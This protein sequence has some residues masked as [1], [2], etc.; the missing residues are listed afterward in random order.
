MWLYGC[1]IEEGS[2]CYWMHL[3][4]KY[5]HCEFHWSQWFSA[6]CIDSVTSRFG[7]PST[8]PNC[9]CPPACYQEVFGIEATRT[10]LPYKVRAV[11]EEVVS[12]SSSPRAQTTLVV[13]RSMSELLVSLSSWRLSR[14][15]CTMNTRRWRF[16]LVYDRHNPHWFQI[17]TF[18]SQFG[19]ILGFILGMSVVGI[20]EILILFGQ[21]GRDSFSTSKKKSWL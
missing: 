9:H 5:N 20:I 12:W 18:L 11:T 2:R 7:E 21:L 15:K 1:P 3:Q 10:A 16:E 14:V 6:D 4:Q 17:W 8:W 19:G 13:M